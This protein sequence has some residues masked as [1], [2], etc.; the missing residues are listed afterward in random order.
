MTTTTPVRWPAPL[1]T[2]RGRDLVQWIADMDNAG[3]DESPEAIAGY[4]TVVMLAQTYG[5]PGDVIGRLVWELRHLRSSQAGEAVRG[6][7]S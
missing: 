4:T 5:V 3:D 2:R 1:N 7:F 6:A